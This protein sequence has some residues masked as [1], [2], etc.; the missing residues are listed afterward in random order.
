MTH[1][2]WRITKSVIMLKNLTKRFDCFPKHSYLC[3]T[4]EGKG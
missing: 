3:K 4:N 2:Q 1:L